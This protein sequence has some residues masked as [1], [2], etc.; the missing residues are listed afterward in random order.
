MDSINKYLRIPNIS[1][2]ALVQFVVGAMQQIVNPN[3]KSTVAK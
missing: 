2:H 3:L 1:Y